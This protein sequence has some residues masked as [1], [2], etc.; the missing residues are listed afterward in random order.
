MF[1]ISKEKYFNTWSSQSPAIMMFLPAQFS[2]GLGAY[3]YADNTY[4]NFP[5]SDSMKLLEHD[6]DGTY[7][8]LTAVHNGTKLL[9]E[10]FKTDEWTVRCRIRVLENGEWGLRFWTFLNLGFEGEGSISRDAGGDVCFRQRS[11]EIAAVMKDAAIR[12]CLAKEYDY[13]GLQMVDKGY[14]A[15]LEDA[16]NPCWHISAYNMEETPVIEFA[17]A[18]CSDVALA[19]RKAAEALALPEEALEG[20][21]SSVKRALQIEGRFPGCGEAIRDVMA[22]NNIADRKN[23][24]T[25]TSLTRFWIDR[26][27]GGWFIWLDDV[28]YH[29]LI[30]TW[31][32]D[33]QMGENNI[34]AAL[35]N[36]VPADNLACL[37]AE[38]TEWVDRSQPPIA[39]FIVLKYY[40]MTHDKVLIEK[41][42]GTL[43]KAHLWWFDHRDG[44]GNGVLEYGSSPGGNGHF[45]RTK[46]AAK[47]EAA[48]D[49]SPMFDGA[50][51]CPETDTIN[52]EDVALNSLLALEGESIAEM[53][54]ILG[55]EEDAK[56]LTRHTQDFKERIDRVLWDEERGLYA[57]RHWEE[58]YAPPSP[59]SFYPLV[60]GIPDEERAKRLIQHIFDE[61]EFWTKAALPSVWKKHPAVTDDVYWRG[62]MWPPLNFFTYLGLKRYGF[63]QEAYRLAERSAEVFHH[64]WETE[65]ACYENYNSFTGVGKSV[66]SDPFYGWGALI[67]LMWVYEFID[68]DSWNGLHFGSVT[69][70]P[71][72]VR[73]V[74]TFNGLYTL[75]C[76]EQTGLWKN[77]T[78]IFTSNAKGRFRQFVYE[79]HYAGVEVGIQ[80]Q[81]VTLSFP[82]ITPLRVRVNGQETGGAWP[83]SLKAGEAYR[84]EIWH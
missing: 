31:S 58:G 34:L 50:K 68:I 1:H 84:V 60:A 10:Y 14:Y 61:E 30:S 66:D 49:N 16:E 19:R 65:R 35:D 28:F 18:V 57:N 15:P 53:A 70:E 80:E 76:G 38:F 42:Y 64:C 55:Y 13:I 83:V 63:E 67:P 33:W 72:E 26:K 20:I 56:M 46:L 27:F 43:K 25:F 79:D 41:V 45:K 7:C 52:M 3:S 39:G 4:T 36:V 77:G 82:A 5:F 62:R 6:A 37:M 74:K 12:D 69:G 75:R 48:M 81:E 51:F 17:A 29:S 2:I 47:D 9:V 71:M 11:Y 24:R 44:D 8:A 54:A 32:G 22:W 73:N 21:R 59:T 78:Q 40:H 23:G